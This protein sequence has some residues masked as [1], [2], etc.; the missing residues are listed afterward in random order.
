MRIAEKYIP[1]NTFSSSKV[2]YEYTVV[3][4]GS[5]NAPAAFRSVVN[6]V[7]KDCTDSFVLVY[8]D[9]VL[10]CR[11]SWD[12]HVRHIKLVLGLIRKQKLYATLSKPASGV[13]E[14]TY[15][16]FVLEAEELAVNSNN[17]EAIKLWEILT[18]EKGPQLFRSLAN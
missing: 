11:S 10:L 16:S 12:K 1:K 15:F 18:H 9:E 3:S 14:V 17:T 8:F 6:K 4:F 7:F 5:T 13:Q 2:H